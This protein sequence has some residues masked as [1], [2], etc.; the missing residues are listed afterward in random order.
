MNKEQK[1]IIKQCL[2]DLE[3]ENGRL[4][5]EDVVTFA[6]SK[7]SP[8]HSFFEWDIKKAAYAHWLAQARGLITSVMVVTTTETT[9]VK[10]VFYVRD[11]RC[12]GNEQGYVSTDTLRTDEDMAREVLIAEFSRAG[13]ALVRARTM[14]KVLALDEEVEKLITGID[15]LR[16]TVTVGVE[17][18]Q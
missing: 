6:K 4:T 5:P 16:A 15:T 1:D 3:K 11:P 2:I 17:A 13:A 10:S 7:D 18:V 14:A 8:I 12:S 9:S